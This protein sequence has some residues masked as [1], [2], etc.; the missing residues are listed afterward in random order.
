MVRVLQC[1]ALGGSCRV[2]RVTTRF[3]RRAPMVGLRPD[4]GASF[5]NPAM[6]RTRKRLRQ[7]ETFFG[8][9]AIRAAISLSCW[10][11]AASNTMRARSATRTGSDRL[12]AWDSNTV[13][14]SGL[15]V[16]AG[17]IRIRDVS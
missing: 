2:V 15:N 6:P 13:R 16:I 17:A 11:E 4:R 7:R 1:V 10:P 3:V 14:C 5:S 8:V 12:R 9:I